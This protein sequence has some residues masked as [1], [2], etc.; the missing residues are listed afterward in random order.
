MAARVIKMSIY[1]LLVQMWMSVAQAEVTNTTYTQKP[2]HGHYHSDSTAKIYRISPFKQTYG[3]TDKLQIG[4]NVRFR[5]AVRH[6]LPKHRFMSGNTEILHR[7]AVDLYQF[8]S[9]R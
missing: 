1:Y 9:R 3:L 6:C 5:L 2:N 4:T 8:Q 7:T